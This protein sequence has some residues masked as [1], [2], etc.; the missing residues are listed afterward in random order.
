MISYR[1]AGSTSRIRGQISSRNQTTESMLESVRKL[2]VLT[3]NFC[4]VASACWA[5]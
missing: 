5:L 4:L 1:A 3:S 2:Q